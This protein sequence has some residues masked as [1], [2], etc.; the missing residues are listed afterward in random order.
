MVTVKDNISQLTHII[1]GL[2]GAVIGGL[3][4]GGARNK[5]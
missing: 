5:G 1:G 3:L 2:C 4:S